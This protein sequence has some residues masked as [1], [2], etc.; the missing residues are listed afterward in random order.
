MAEGDIG[1]VFQLE[2][3]VPSPW[4]S[5]LIEEERRRAYS[6]VLVA[7]AEDEI[8]SWCCTRAIKSEAEL[9]KL[10]VAEEWRRRSAGTT[11][12]AA[13]EQRLLKTGV[14]WLY[15]EVRSANQPAIS[16]YR[17][18]GFTQV[19]KRINYYS[20]PKDDALIFKKTND[21]IYHGTSSHEKYQRSAVG[22]PAGLGEGGF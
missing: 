19:G 12:L 3:Q 18:A 5:S 14:Q 21:H 2:S 10:V 20:Q 13:L 22:R 16:F 17:Q 1:D 11:L 15:L 9:L 4:S 6:I 7:V 8:I